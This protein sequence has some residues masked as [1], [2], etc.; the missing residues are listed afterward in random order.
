MAT[1]AVGAAASLNVAVLAQDDGEE[2]I[3]LGGNTPGWIPYRLPGDE[4]ADDAED[5]PTLALEAGTTYTLAWVNVDGQPHNVAIRDS[6]GEN[7][8]VLQ[9][10]DD[11]GSDQFE[12]LN[13]TE[14][15]ETEMNET[16][17]GDNETD[18]N[19]TATTVPEEELVDATENVTEEGAVQAVRFTASEEM[20]TYICE[21]HPTTMEGDVEIEG[22]DGNGEENNS[23]A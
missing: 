2:Y 4:S 12:E 21:V 11:F 5:N 13:Q 8:Q 1:A 10:L 7:L 23:S 19:E 22:G 20:A 17:M 14:G 3:L 9:V 15:N 16:E 18:G 6:E